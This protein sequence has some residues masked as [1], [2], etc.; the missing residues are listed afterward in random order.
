MD[1]QKAAN[2]LK[3]M[4]AKNKLKGEEKEAVETAIGILAWVALGKNRLKVRKARL[5]KS[6]EW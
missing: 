5:E 4:L 3:D 6:T 2:V 1:Y